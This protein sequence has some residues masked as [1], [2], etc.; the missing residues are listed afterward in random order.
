MA[1]LVDIWDSIGILEEQRV[2]RMEAVKKHIDLLLNEMIT[3]EEHLKHR[4]ELSIITCQKQLDTLYLELSVE[5]YQI[6]DG[7]TVLQL[8]KDLRT[9]MEALAKERNDRLKELESLREDDNALCIELCTTPY[10]IPTGSLPSRSQLQDLRE[11]IKTLTEE[12]KNRVKVFSGLRQDISQLMSEIG[13]SP[14]TSVEKEA[15]CDDADVFLLTNENIKALQ[16]LKFQLEVKK[17]SLTLTQGELKEKVLNLWNR[18]EFTEQEKAAFEDNLKASLSDE[19]ADWQNELERLEELKK[20]NLQEVIEKIR[21]ELT[22]YWETCKFGSEQKNSCTFFFDD[23]FTEEL[24]T[25]HDE[26]LLRV[27]EYYKN[28]KPM[29][30][31]VERWEKNWVLFQDFERKASDPNRFS[32]RG[33]TLLKDAKERV[34]VQKMLPKLEEDL[35]SSIEI[36]EA[37]QGTEFLIGGLRIMDYIGRQWE[38]HRLLKGKEKSERVSNLLKWQC[39]ETCISSEAHGTIGKDLIW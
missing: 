7:L 35:K 14:E 29:L 37:E 16:M 6:D 12:K 33:G 25:K 19:I 11:H 8:E 4:I 32:N 20:A 28:A 1:R 5:P 15:V 22:E 39:V 23:N 9:K 27:K 34:K 38:E 17:D 3:E 31:N 2:E 18:L 21:I 10:Y 26:E 24:L 36:W 13:H 30:E